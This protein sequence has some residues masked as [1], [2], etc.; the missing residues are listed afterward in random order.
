MPL[1]ST[2]SAA[3]SAACHASSEDTEAHLLPVQWGIIECEA[4]QPARCSFTTLRTVRAPVP[5]EILLG[6]P[7]QERGS[8]GGLQKRVRECILRLRNLGPKYHKV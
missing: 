3:I 4:G 5:D 2:C 7:R 8:N 6:L 1:V